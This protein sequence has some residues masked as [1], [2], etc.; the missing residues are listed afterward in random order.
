M[1]E[2]RMS[3]VINNRSNRFDEKMPNFLPKMYWLFTAV[4]R[5]QIYFLWNFSYFFYTKYI[6]KNSWIFHQVKVKSIWP[7]FDGQT[8]FMVVKVFTTQIINAMPLFIGNID[9][10]NWQWNER[11]IVNNNFLYLNWKF[12]NL[13]FEVLDTHFELLK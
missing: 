5:F 13:P 4:R 12:S 10:K 8:P 2:F 11:R 9:K 1:V 3:N 7:Y 6:E